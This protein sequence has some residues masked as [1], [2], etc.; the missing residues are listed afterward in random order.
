M[1]ILAAA[2]IVALAT[3]T[4]ADE[5][6]FGAPAPGGAPATLAPA[7]PDRSP[8]YG[9]TH[10]LIPGMLIGPKLSILS[11]PTPSIG[12]EAKL[13]GNRLG[14]SFDYDLMPNVDLMDVEV[15]YTDWNLAAKVYPWQGSF[16]VGAA[17]GSRSFWAKAT[18]ATSG[19]VVKAEVATKYL[20]PEI[21]WRFVWNGGFFMGMDLGY[22]I[23]LSNS[24]T[25]KAGDY[26][27]SQESKDVQ[28]A[29]DDLGKIG[30]PI[31]T[32]L[33]AGYFF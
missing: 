4:L 21:G 9:K 24:V 29:A 19:Y 22:Q 18:E 20:A 23:V 15:G 26:S 25:V 6:H 12:V 32:L 17:F 14:F 10:G 27:L 1:R 2:L 33:Q 3:P 7:A 30:F 28:D 5:T 31:V 8:A 11:I 13:M 16:F